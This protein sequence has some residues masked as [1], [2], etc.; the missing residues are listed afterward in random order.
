M[1]LPKWLITKWLGVPHVSKHKALPVQYPYQWPIAVAVVNR[2]LRRSDCRLIF[3]GYSRHYWMYEGEKDML[4]LTVILGICRTKS[5]ARRL[6]VA[7]TIPNGYARTTPIK[8]RRG[9]TIE[10]LYVRPSPRHRRVEG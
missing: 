1:T 6:G 8:K 3:Y 10:T 5:E 9:S 7:Q 4:D 2:R